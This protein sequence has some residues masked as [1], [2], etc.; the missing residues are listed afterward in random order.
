M[1]EER[2][3]R[4]KQ[5]LAESPDDP[6]LYYAL[7]MEYK[8]EQPSRALEYLQHVYQHF[9][10][11]CAVYYPLAH[12]YWD[13][14]FRKQAREVFEQGLKICEQLAEAKLLEELRTAYRLFL[15]EEE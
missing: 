3:A 5:W 4:L 8:Q 7:A 10:T 12:L 9:P 2:I 15:L 11:Y 1:H 14:G 13:M 6:F